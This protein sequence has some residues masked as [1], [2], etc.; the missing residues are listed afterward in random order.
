M[1][2]AIL[3]EAQR[4]SL[5]LLR[6]NFGLS[7]D[8][9]ERCLF[10]RTDTDEPWLPPDITMAIARAS[11]RITDISAYFDQYV[12]ALDQ[13]VFIATAKDP[14]G[15][16]Y[17]R[18]GV[19]KIGEKPNG[20]EIDHNILAEGRALNAALTAAGVNPFKAGTVAKVKDQFPRH[21]G[22]PL[23]D[24]E[25]ERQRITDEAIS[26]NNDLRAIHAEAAKKDLILA[27][28]SGGKNMKNY[29][30]WLLKHF[31]VHTAAVLDQ[32]Q[33]ASVIKALVDHGQDEDEI[34]LELPQELRADAAIA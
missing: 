5:D 19:A 20:I 13:V 28:P 27:L 1:T 12:A 15:R 33:R 17:S 9:L 14:E 6:V 31:G 25:L 10:F 22:A 8:E 2:R 29:R 3:T 18:T 7:D 30:N 32:T 23:T 21:S 26:R 11:G 4:K 24:S 16:S 34:I